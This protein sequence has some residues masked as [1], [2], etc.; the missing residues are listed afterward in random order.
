MPM[1]VLMAVNVIVFAMIY[2]FSLFDEF[3]WVKGKTFVIMMIPACLC[4]Y[5]FIVLYSLYKKIGLED[6][7]RCTTTAV[8]YQHGTVNMAINP[9]LQG[10]M[11]TP[12][13]QPPPTYQL[14]Q[15]ATPIYYSQQVESPPSYSSKAQYGKLMNENECWFMRIFLYQ[16]FGNIQ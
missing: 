10:M 8:Q 15:G 5:C 11:V 3:Y 6:Q 4:S 12:M 13:Y 9:A 16:K 2:M 7:N 14:P 1:I